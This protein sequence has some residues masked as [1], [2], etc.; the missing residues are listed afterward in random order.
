MK[1]KL[2]VEQIV[3]RRSRFG[4]TVFIRDELGYWWK[5]TFATMEDVPPAKVEA[6]WND[7]F[8]AWTKTEEPA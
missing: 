6:S 7:N 5:C 1:T 3:Q 4:V 2:R 8:K